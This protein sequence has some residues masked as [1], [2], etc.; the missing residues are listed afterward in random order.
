MTIPERVSAQ[1]CVIEPSKVIG[2][3]AP[4][5][6]MLIISVGIIDRAASITDCEVRSEKPNGGEGQASKIASGFFARSNFELLQVN[7]NSFI[8]EKLSFRN[9]PVI[10]LLLLYFNALYN[11]CQS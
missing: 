7:N 5:I 3:F 2:A 10:I 9:V 6:G 11:L 4:A 1:C 8:I